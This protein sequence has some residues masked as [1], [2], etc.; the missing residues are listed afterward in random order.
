MKEQ[1]GIRLA[2]LTLGFLPVSAYGLSRN[3]EDQTGNNSH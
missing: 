2:R 3:P 1:H